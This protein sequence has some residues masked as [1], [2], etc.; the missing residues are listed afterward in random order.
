[1]KT[2]Q[3]YSLEVGSRKYICPACGQKTFVRFVNS[4]TGKYLSEKHGRC[5]REIKCGYFQKPERK[6]PNEFSVTPIWQMKKT[7]TNYDKNIL[8]ATLINRFGA[9]AVRNVL[10]KF[11]IGTGLGKYEGW[12][13]FWQVDHLG[14]IR[15]GHMM[16]Y[17]GLNRTKYQTWTHSLTDNNY[18]L[19]QCFFGLNQLKHIPADKQINIVESEKTALVGSIYFPN[20]TWM[21]T[22][23]KNNLNSDSMKWLYPHPVHLY[24][25]GDSYQAWK[26]VAEGNSNI[27]VIDWQHDFLGYPMKL[28]LGC[29]IA[30][31]LIS[32]TPDEL[33]QFSLN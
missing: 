33:K 17:I 25:D 20:E 8:I 14:Y 13:I 28:D 1:M 12:T 2:K 27:Y 7:C 31:F 32:H 23:G 26:K 3:I 10:S 24:P 5:D 22:C 29:D 21:A 6:D 11:Y 15:T 30:D 18:R 16:Q 9:D 19:K 4:E